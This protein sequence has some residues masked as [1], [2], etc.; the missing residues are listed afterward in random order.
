[1]GGGGG[2]MNEGRIGGLGKLGRGN[3]GLDLKRDMES[4]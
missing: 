2:G 4:G 1:M 3:E